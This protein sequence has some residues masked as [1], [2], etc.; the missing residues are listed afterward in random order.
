[1]CMHPHGIVPFHAGLWAAYADQYLCDKESG[2]ALYG[3]GAAADAVGYVPVLRNIMGW[4]S[5][6]SAS[7]KVLKNGITK[8][9]PLAFSIFLT[10]N[11][12]QFFSDSCV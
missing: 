11:F 10:P 1:M 6:G 3:F 4:L 9:C 5:A 2:R 12:Q 8:V 7:Y